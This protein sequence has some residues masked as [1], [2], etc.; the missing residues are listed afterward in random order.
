MNLHVKKSSL[1]DTHIHNTNG[2]SSIH[3]LRLLLHD[4]SDVCC[5]SRT[6][7][8]NQNQRRLGLLSIHLGANNQPELRICL[9]VFQIGMLPRHPLL[10]VL[11]FT[12][13]L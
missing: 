5:L 11:S 6:F 9:A 10:Q 4:A 3:R 8:A 2:I 13:R 7:I 12:E 1:F